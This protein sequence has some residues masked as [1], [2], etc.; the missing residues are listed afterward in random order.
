MTDDID[1]SDDDGW[2]TVKTEGGAEIR[3][4]LFRTHNLLVDYHRKNAQKS[5]EEYADGVLA[6]MQGW[7]LPSCSHRAVTRFIELIGDR[8]GQ[9]K[10]KD[11]L[12]PALPASTGSTPSS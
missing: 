1:L 8:V 7:G 5:E 10:K 4:D 2:V 9:L 3:L 6:M 12:R 11:G